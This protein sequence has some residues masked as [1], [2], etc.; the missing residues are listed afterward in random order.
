MAV[1]TRAWVHVCVSAPAKLTF[2]TPGGHPWRPIL[3]PGVSVYFSRVCQHQ[4]I[5]VPKLLETSMAFP[6]SRDGSNYLV[7]QWNQSPPCLS[8]TGSDSY[9]WASD[10]NARTRTDDF[11][12]DKLRSSKFMPQLLQFT[13]WRLHSNWNNWAA[14]IGVYCYN[15]SIYTISFW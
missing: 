11:G 10:A 13:A 9:Y 6:G 1:R 4:G 14:C 12:F 15:C 8:G 7:S 3:A 2:P 5:V